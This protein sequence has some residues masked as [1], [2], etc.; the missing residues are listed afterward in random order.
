MLIAHLYLPLVYYHKLFNTL[1][2]SVQELLC[3]IARA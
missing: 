2:I 3:K 1:D